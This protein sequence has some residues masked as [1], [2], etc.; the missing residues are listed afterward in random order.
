MRRSWETEASRA[1]RVSSVRRSTSASRASSRSRARST[2]RAIWSAAASTSRASSADH[3][4]RARRRGRGAGRPPCARAALSGTNVTRCD[5]PRAAP[6]RG[7]VDAHPAPPGPGGAGRARRGHHPL[8]RRPLLRRR[9]RPGHRPGHRP[10]P[11]HGVVR[12]EH[13]APG[14]VQRRAQVLGH[15]PQR[16]VHVV[17]RAQDAPQLVQRPRLALAPAGLLRPVALGRRQLPGDRGDDQEQ[18]AGP[19]T[20]GG[21]PR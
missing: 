3:G 10:P 16:G 13:G 7:V 19:P 9:G 15:L 17:A 14:Q 1:R 2:A 20:P 6:R 8:R 12:E 11:A 4:G 21:R 5:V 18:H